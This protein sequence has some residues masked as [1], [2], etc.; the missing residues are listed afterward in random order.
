MLP[1]CSRERRRSR[2]GLLEPRRT[3]KETL[4]TPLQRGGAP[5]ALCRD[6]TALGLRGWKTKQPQACCETLT[7][8][9]VFSPPL[10]WCFSTLDYQLPR[11]NSAHPVPAWQASISAFA[12]RCYCKAGRN[13][14]VHKI[15][16]LSR[17]SGTDETLWTAAPLTTSLRTPSGAGPTWGTATPASAN[18]PTTTRHSTLRFPLL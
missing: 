3:Q 11:A 18:A 6:C 4:Q 5:P 12:S 17:M 15:R 13:N 10:S 1:S 7:M 8:S 9:C 14:H 16:R 2:T